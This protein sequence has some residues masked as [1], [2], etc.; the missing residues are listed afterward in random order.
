[1]ASHNL[2]EDNEAAIRATNDDAFSS[3]LAALHAGYFRDPHL[4]TLFR[5]SHTAK[6][7]RP[8]VIN[9]GTFARVVLKRTVLD[10][11][12]ALHAS[13]CQIVSLGAGFDTAPFYSGALRFVELDLPEVV[14]TKVQ[15]AG[16]LLDAVYDHV[17]VTD[18]SVSARKNGEAGRCHYELRACDILNI[19]S[20]TEALSSAGIDPSL[21]TL[22][23]AEI[24]LVYL[25]PN[26]ADMLLTHLHNHFTKTRA[27]LLLEHTNL[28]DPFGETM[29]R[30]I[31]SRGCPLLGLSKYPTIGSLKDR[32]RGAGFGNVRAETMMDAFEARFSAQQKRDL[33]KVEMLDEVEEFRLLLRHYV[34]LIAVAGDDADS[35]VDALTMTRFHGTA[36]Q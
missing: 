21:P 23:L 17:R 30:N 27:V 22:I 32:F 2:A 15:L 9:R 28:H 4:E 5:H 16:E 24:V 11:F 35:V 12:S 7:A 20:V 26:A 8:P 10:A 6:P 34:V 1:M 19:G 18:R 36:F 33:Q 3:K 13:R 25:P 29:A 31:A 14:C